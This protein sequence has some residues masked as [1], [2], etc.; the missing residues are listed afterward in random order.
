MNDDIYADLSQAMSAA[1]GDRQPS[2]ES[3]FHRHQEYLSYGLK[4]AEIRRVLKTFRPRIRELPLAERLEL[5]ARLLA[6]HIG[7]LGHAGIHVQAL[8]VNELGP[9]HFPYL[10]QTAGDWRSWSHVDHFCGDV[11]QP[12]LARLPEATLAQIE[13]W[14]ESP[15]RWKRRA[16][17]VAFTRRVGESG[18]YT[19]AVLSLCDRLKWDPEDIVQK[20]VGWALKDNMRSA[21]EQVTAY[22]KQ[23]RREG[24]PSTITLYAIR[25]LKGPARQEILAVKP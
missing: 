21:P 14:S 18:R 23:L 8:S 4:A 11:L 12:L 7:E 25:D 9:G 1:A 17:V 13:A 19:G 20:G 3:R 16:S 2:P 5:A 10:D 6:Q 15:N 22:V 24:V